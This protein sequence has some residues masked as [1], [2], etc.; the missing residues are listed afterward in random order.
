MIYSA[1]VAVE[2]GFN[3]RGLFLRMFRP[4]R[5]CPTVHIGLNHQWLLALLFLLLFQQCSL[6]KTQRKASVTGLQTAATHDGKQGPTLHLPQQLASWIL[7]CRVIRNLPK[8]PQPT[9]CW[10]TFCWKQQIIK[11]HRSEQPTS[12]QSLLGN[13]PWENNSVRILAVKQWEGKQG[14]EAEMPV[15]VSVN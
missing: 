4:A 15:S 11:I 8:K 6:E 2:I 14:H 10:N 3:Q 13:N 7:G 1:A 5:P 12:C 9:H